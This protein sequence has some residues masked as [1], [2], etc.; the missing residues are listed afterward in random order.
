MIFIEIES[1]YGDDI[2][3]DSLIPQLSLFR[4]MVKSQTLVSF[5]YILEI[6]K[7]I[8]ENEG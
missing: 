5:D 7:Q 4:T 8:P 2:D 1:N 3:I 6:V